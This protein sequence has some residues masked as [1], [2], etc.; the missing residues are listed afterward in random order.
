LLLKR[1]LALPIPFHSPYHKVII[2][3]LD[4][5]ISLAFVFY[6]LPFNNLRFPILPSQRKTEQPNTSQPHQPFH[7]TEMCITLGYTLYKKQ[8]KKKAAGQ[9]EYSDPASKPVPNQT[10]PAYPAKPGNHTYPQGART[11]NGPPPGVP[12]Y[13][14]LLSGK[15]VLSLKNDEA[16]RLTWDLILGERLA[17]GF[18]AMYIIYQC[19]D[20]RNRRPYNLTVCAL[21]I[22]LFGRV[23]LF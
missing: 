5:N 9:T 6:L 14:S 17:Y 8:Q 15:G 18:G 20:R 19:E 1:R 12:A 16:D 23:I 21:L 3:K 10:P 7:L 4:S 22:I 13:Q 11:A 2:E